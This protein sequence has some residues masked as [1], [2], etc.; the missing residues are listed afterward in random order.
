MI[1]VIFL[2]A[3]LT[4]G[5][6]SLS[7]L[8]QQQADAPELKRIQ[9]ALDSDKDY[10]VFKKK[11]D[12]ISQSANGRN[13][14]VDEVKKLFFDN[15]S[16]FQGLQS[17]YAVRA[18]TPSKI[19]RY[20]TVDTN[21]SV[22]K[23]Q[24]GLY[25]KLGNLGKFER[26]ILPPY[27]QK[28]SFW[29]SVYGG[30]WRLRETNTNE[31]AGRIG[32]TVNQTDAFYLSSG[33]VGFQQDFTVPSD[34]TILAAKITI[35]YSFFFTGWDTYPADLGVGLF[36]NV[37]PNFNSAYVNQLPGYMSMLGL[38]TWKDLGDL[39]PRKAVPTLGEVAEFHADVDSS[40]TATGYVSPGSVL[41]FRMGT[42]YIQ[43]TS[44]QQTFY[45]QRGMHGTYHYGEFII[46]KITINYL[47]T[48]Q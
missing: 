48:L 22:L 33:T 28:W 3:L 42:G 15:K 44:G 46:R 37:S 14:K 9:K 39:V 27:T 13:S 6:F 24:L 40:F 31:A 29:Y 21:G 11:L 41:T 20:Q 17:K 36:L 35:D 8:A 30:T 38:N 45:S 12:E 19:A 32:F 2:T 4:V 5:S 18:L 34:P 10:Q 7:S 47:K 23:R 26:K 43:R 25:R 1:K 16:L